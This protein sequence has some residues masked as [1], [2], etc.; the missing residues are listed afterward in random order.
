VQAQQWRSAGSLAFSLP[1]D[2]QQDVF[3]SG[4]AVMAVTAPAAGLQV[5]LDI[6]LSRRFVTELQNRSA[7]IRPAFQI[8][9]AG[10]KNPDRLT[11]QGFQLIAQNTLVLP[12]S[13]E[14]ALGRS[15]SVLAQDQDQTGLDT[16]L[17]VK[18]VRDK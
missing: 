16:P 13:L 1:D 17:R 5:H 15:L 3:K 12:N 9:E 18:V 10:M 14:Q 7:E 11:V 2:V 6:A 8:M 4:V